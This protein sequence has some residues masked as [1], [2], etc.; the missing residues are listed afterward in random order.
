MLTEQGG[1]EPSIIVVSTNMAAT[2]AWISSGAVLWLI[3]IFIP[4]L[5]KGWGSILS[6][7]PVPPPTC[8]R[9]CTCML[10]A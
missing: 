3:G 8:T 1:A 9:I 4:F 2:I 7:P 5:L 6:A 10:I